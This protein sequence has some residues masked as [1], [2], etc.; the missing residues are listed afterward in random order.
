ML[1]NSEKLLEQAIA[2]KNDVTSRLVPNV[3]NNVILVS[4][5]LMAILVTLSSPS[6]SNILLFRSLLCMLLCGIFFGVL[7]YLLITFDFYTLG[8]KVSEEAKE[9]YTSDKPKKEIHSGKIFYYSILISFVLTLFS[10]LTSLVLLL[11]Y[12]WDFK[13]K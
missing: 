9:L 11:L 10:F 5:S 1:S 7:C 8:I 4:A 13:A 3:L 6:M 12:A 2:I